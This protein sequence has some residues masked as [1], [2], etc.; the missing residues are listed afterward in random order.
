[1]EKKKKY[2]RPSVEVLVLASQGSMLVGVSGK[3]QGGTDY[4]GEFEPVTPAKPEVPGGYN[5]WD[6]E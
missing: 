1:M 6:G 4:G 2:E 3:T 5:P